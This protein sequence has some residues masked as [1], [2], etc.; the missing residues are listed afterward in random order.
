MSDKATTADKTLFTPFN[1]VAGFIIIIGAVITILRFTGGLAAVTN[2]SDNNPWGVW[3]GFDLLVGVAL[4]AGGYVTSAA[5]YL[6]GMKKY[7][8]A[9]RPAVLTGFLGYA[10]VVF[11]LHYDVGR[12]WR[13]PYPFIIQSGTTSLLFE[14]GAC[15][16]LYLTVLFLEFTPAPLEW[17]G[18][19]KVRELV[20]KMTLVLTIFGVVLS[21][22]HQSSLGALFLI[23]PSKL[24]PLW[25][26]PY[27]PVY[28]FISSIIA[29]LSMVIFES[30]LSHHYFADKM[31][32]AHLSENEGVTLG[33]AKAAS[34]VLAGYFIIKIIGISFSDNWYLL[35]TSYGIWFLVEILGFVALPS[36]LYAVGVRDK[37]LKLI[38]WTSLLA[39]L[40]IIL[41]R[42]NVSL[43]AFNWH[44]PSSER[45]F[46]HWMEIAISL[47]IVTVGIVVFRFIVTRMPIFYGHPDYK[48]SH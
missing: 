21:T 20:V 6:F 43:I 16:A 2:L 18:L 5:V 14:V 23:A 12:P 13:L 7:H 22:L 45:Y 17:L 26:S 19:K 44:L 35:G 42:L 25:Y 39:V 24:H 41:N 8:S 30:T 37:N 15:V 33:F 38:K 10:L 48:D 11:A 46:P 29:G 47:F 32:E 9:V 31:D 27:L 3:I 4:A 34:F 36:F 40:G 28:F 1:V